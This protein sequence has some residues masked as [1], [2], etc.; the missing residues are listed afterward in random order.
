MNLLNFNS[1]TCS[2]IS[3]KTS[4]QKLWR[5]KMIV[6]YTKFVQNSWNELKIKLNFYN[7]VVLVQLLTWK[8]LEVKRKKVARFFVAWDITSITKIDK[9]ATRFVTSESDW[10]SNPVGFLT[11]NRVS[12]QLQQGK[13]T[14]LDNLFVP[15]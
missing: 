13:D 1:G 7:S 4:W 15:E 10:K 14:V 3:K 11:S 9:R 2:K 5:I 12:L 6:Q 8:K